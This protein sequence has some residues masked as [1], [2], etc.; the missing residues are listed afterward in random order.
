MYYLGIDPGQSGGSVLLNEAGEILSC[1]SF[2]Q[3]KEEWPEAF[4]QYLSK[5]PFRPHTY[6][7][8][9]HAMPKQGVS[10]MFTFGKNFGL[11]KGVCL[12][13]G[14]TY[15]L[16]TPRVWTK[17]VWLTD[18]GDSKTRSIF[19]AHELWGTSPFIRTKRCLK[20]DSGLVDAALI[21]EYGRRSKG[22]TLAA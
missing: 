21:A 20:P 22:Q 12:A 3:Y 5:M 10:S 11:V 13:L 8:S 9:V 1:L 17:A 19:T 6:L 16:V 2:T 15:T 18:D 7:E 14:F 4:A